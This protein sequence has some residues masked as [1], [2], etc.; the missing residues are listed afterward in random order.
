MF[1]LAGI[2]WTLSTTMFIYALASDDSFRMSQVALFVQVT[3]CMPTLW[4]I[5]EHIVSEHRRILLLQLAEV[6][7]RADAERQLRLVREAR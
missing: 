5:F 1:A 7:G 6:V 2:L 3:A 4:L